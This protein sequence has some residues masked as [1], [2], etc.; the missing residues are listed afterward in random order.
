M[1]YQDYFLLFGD[2][3]LHDS[4]LVLTQITVLFNVKIA[5]FLND[6]ACSTQ[7]LLLFVLCRILY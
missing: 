4:H 6:Y 5:L 1:E 7:R 3:Y 2:G